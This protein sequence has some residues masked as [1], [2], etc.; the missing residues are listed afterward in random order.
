MIH[1]ERLIEA[2]KQSGVTRIA[3]VDDAFD[4]P[5]ISEKSWGQVLEFLQGETAAEIRDEMQ[6]TPEKWHAAIAAINETSYDADELSECVNVLY[7]RFINTFDNRFD[8]GGVFKVEKG[9]NLLNVRPIIELLKK[10]H[11]EINI[12]TF[13][14]DS[15]GLKEAGEVHMVFVDL[16]LDSNIAAASEP[17]LEEGGGAVE[18]SLRRIGP[19]MMQEPSVVLMSSHAKRSEAETYRARIENR[20]FASRFTFIEKTKVQQLSDNTINVDGEAA[21]AL[22]DIFQSYKFGRGLNTTLKCWLKSAEVAVEKLGK[23]I[24]Q[25]DLKEIAYLVKFRLASEGQDLTEYLEWFFGEC[26]IDEVARQVDSSTKAYSHKEL[27]S[28]KAA[29]QIEGAF[30]GPTI[31]VARMYH[32]VRI[33][34]KRKITRENFRLGDLYLKKTVGKP[35]SLVAVMTPDC[36]LVKRENG[37]RGASSMLTVFGE[38]SKFDAPQ[39]SV[40][41]FIMIKDQPHNISWKYKKVQ[42]F[43]FKGPMYAPGESQ[44]GFEYLGA[45]RPLYAQEIQ[46]NLLHQLGRVGVFVSPAMGMSA[47]VTLTVLNNKSAKVLYALEG[48][49][50]TQ[51]YFVPA[52]ES[53]HKGQVIFKRHF[54][55]SFLSTISKLQDNDVPVDAVKYLKQL[56]QPNAYEKLS[57]ISSGMD[58]EEFIDF[59]IF[60]TGNSKFKVKSAE[61]VWCWL[62]ISINSPPID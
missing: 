41:D 3:I 22:L 9:T 37:K 1:E 42:T 29:S 44:R 16:F 55:R 25:L 5:I 20:V 8:P 23:E 62:T 30:D 31:N 28:P 18:A 24:E 59:K 10:C 6:I 40:G 36:D 53:Q 61:G 56:K 12:C 19:L 33:E 39:T 26:L 15:D 49:N 60:L 57:K 27:L 45:L 52:R 4:T 2:I 14:A 34:G 46:R 21:D 51:C 47:S 48:P 32:R 38:L 17:T 50:E 35:D 11:P 54:V 43:A 58:L 7:G 13:G